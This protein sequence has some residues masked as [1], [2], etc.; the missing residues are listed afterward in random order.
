MN[1]IYIKTS[2]LNKWIAKYFPNKDL[3]SI[4][5]LI[6]CIEDL[7]IEIDNLNQQ[8]EEIK[9]DITDNYKRKT[10]AEQVRIS[11]SDFM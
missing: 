8:L 1:E 2:D 10:V 11:D 9:E 6:G 7:D 3:I 5:E 4:T